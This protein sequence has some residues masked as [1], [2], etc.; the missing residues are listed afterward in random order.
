MIHYGI[1][2]I[3]PGVYYTMLK[4][5][6]NDDVEIIHCLENNQTTIFT[7]SNEFELMWNR[8]IGELAL[9]LKDIPVIDL[10]EAIEQIQFE[11]QKII[12]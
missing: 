12:S 11:K 7:D 2:Q 9:Y 10:S 8:D 6:A 5:A 3:E 4:V 1:V